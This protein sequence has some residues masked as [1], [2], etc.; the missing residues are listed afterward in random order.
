MS[1]CDDTLCLVLTLS[2]CH[3]RQNYHHHHW[4]TDLRPEDS[5][6]AGNEEPVLVWTDMHSP[7][8]PFTRETLQ[9]ISPSPRQVR[10]TKSAGNGVSCSLCTTGNYRRVIKTLM[11][12]PEERDAYFV[13]KSIRVLCRLGCRVSSWQG[14][15]TDD[16]AL[17][18]LL[19]TRTKHQIKLM[20]G[21]YLERS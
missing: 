1:Y 4:F 13:Y 18:E 15:G 11:M 20:K 17:V 12:S 16:S 19:C 14:I 10:T 9:R 2:S 5:N 6:C 21:A 7:T 3:W 8:M